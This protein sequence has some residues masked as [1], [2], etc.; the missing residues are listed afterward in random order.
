MAATRRGSRSVT[1]T[2]QE[3]KDDQR[4]RRAEQPEQDED[5]LGS[6]LSDH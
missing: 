5:H 3:E 2:Q 1:D 6:L 4:E